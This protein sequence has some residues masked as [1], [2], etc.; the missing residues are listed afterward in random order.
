VDYST[1][2]EG[3]YEI[4][5]Y[6]APGTNWLDVYQPMVDLILDSLKWQRKDT[7]NWALR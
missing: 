2:D 5:I 6:M 7:A 1:I 4:V 3:N